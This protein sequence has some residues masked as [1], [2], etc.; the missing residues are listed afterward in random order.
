[1]SKLS[2]KFNNVPVEEDTRILDRRECTLGEYEVL[3]E[4]W[5]WDGIAGSTIVFCT[6]DIA[7]VKHRDLEDFVRN[8][9]VIDEDSKVTIKRTEEGFTFVNFNFRA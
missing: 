1:M 9:I 6:R 5:V 3:F 2:S 7:T 8:L 4:R